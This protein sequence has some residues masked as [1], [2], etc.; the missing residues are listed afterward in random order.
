MLQAIE[1]E[2]AEQ[3]DRQLVELREEEF[4]LLKLLAKK[5]DRKTEQ[6]D[7]EQGKAA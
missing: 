3:V 5:A 4:A 6:E 7:S 1:T 2:V